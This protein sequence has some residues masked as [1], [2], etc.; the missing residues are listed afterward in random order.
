MT[1]VLFANL[2]TELWVVNAHAFAW[3]HAQHAN[4]SFVHIF[5]HLVCGVAGLA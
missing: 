2:F 4:F 1:K 5:V 3:G